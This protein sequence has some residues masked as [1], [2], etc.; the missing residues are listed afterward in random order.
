MHIFCEVVKQGIFC[1]VRANHQL[2]I[3]QSVFF[4]PDKL[5]LETNFYIFLVNLSCK[6]HL[7]QKY[8][9]ILEVLHRVQSLFGHLFIEGKV[10]L[11]FHINSHHYIN[12]LDNVGDQ[13]I[14]ETCQ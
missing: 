8:I 4:V 6:V 10:T 1:E 13:I 3:C 9:H 11:Q 2:R 5:L 12:L 14:I 7:D